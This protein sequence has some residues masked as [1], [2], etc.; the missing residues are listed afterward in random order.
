MNETYKITREQHTYMCECIA[1]GNKIKA[2]KA[3]REATGTGLAEA[4][5]I[6]DNW[7]ETGFPTCDLEIQE[8]IPALSTPYSYDLTRDKMIEGIVANARLYMSELDA[9]TLKSDLEETT[10][11]VSGSDKRNIPTRMLRWIYWELYKGKLPPEKRSSPEY[12]N[13]MDALNK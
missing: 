4:K 9:D 10:M 7:I 8:E 6:I 5:A 3:A 13:V 12:I 2:I 11:M 1:S